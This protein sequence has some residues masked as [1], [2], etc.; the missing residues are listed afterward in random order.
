MMTG[1]KG[2]LPDYNMCDRLGDKTNDGKRRLERHS[3][4]TAGGGL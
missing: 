4:G 3:R 1:S 2:R